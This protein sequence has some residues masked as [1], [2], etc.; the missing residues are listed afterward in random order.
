VNEQAPRPLPANI[1][2]SGSRDESLAGG[3][4]AS[5][6][7]ASLR[8]ELVGLLEARR[9]V[10]ARAVTWPDLAETQERVVALL[11]ELRF[12]GGDAASASERLLARSYVCAR[13]LGHDP[14][15]DRLEHE[16][17]AR[18]AAEERAKHE[19]LELAAP[20]V[21]RRLVRG[22]FNAAGDDDEDE[23]DPLD[24]ERLTSSAASSSGETYLAFARRQRPGVSAVT[25]AVR[26]SEAAPG[27]QPS[28]LAPAF[29]EEAARRDRDA[30]REAIARALY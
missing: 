13:R 12:Q 16:R 29:D 24:G 23:L 7:H 1:V 14:V 25:I 26:A 2:S 9:Q 11:Q 15:D 27:A 19:P 28:A 3:L 17:V 8:G 10:F 4:G 18:A 6:P 21:A 30:A 22:H 5:S 20:V